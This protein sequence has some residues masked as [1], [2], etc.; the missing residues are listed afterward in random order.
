LDLYVERYKFNNPM[1]NGRKLFGTRWQASLQSIGKCLAEQLIIAP[2]EQVSQHSLGG[3]LVG[4]E[5]RILGAVARG[6]W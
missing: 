1:A 3:L 4:I 6:Y 5:Y 2:S